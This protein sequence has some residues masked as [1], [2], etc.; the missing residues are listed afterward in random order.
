MLWLYVPAKVIIFEILIQWVMVLEGS[1]L[2]DDE[3]IRT[4]QEWA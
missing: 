4:A 1:A 2:S 3:V